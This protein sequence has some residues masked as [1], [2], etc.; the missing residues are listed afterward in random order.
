[1]ASTDKTEL[2]LNK[3]IGTDIPEMN[4][5]NSDNSIIDSE[6]NRKVDVSETQN[7]RYYSF[8]NINSKIIN[9]SLVYGITNNGICY[10][11][12]FI[13]VGNALNSS[14]TIGSIPYAPSTQFTSI[15]H[16][17]SERQLV[18]LNMT[19]NGKLENVQIISTG[20]FYVA[21]FSFPINRKI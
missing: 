15:G 20:I 1:M 8:L 13:Q 19:V 10:V 21:T 14:E 6:L 2:G 18:E 5:F 7:V 11:S 16:I 4:D 12:G 3:W 9:S 17:R